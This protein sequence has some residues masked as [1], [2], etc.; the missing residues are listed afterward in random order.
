MMIFLDTGPAQ[1]TLAQRE[2]GDAIGLAQLLTPLTRYSDRGGMY[3]IDNGAFSRFDADGF[4]RLLDRQSSSVDRCKFV[5][6]P[7]VVGSGIRTSEV[8]ERWA[9][10][11]SGWPLAYV[12]QDGCESL[13]IPWDSIAAVFIGGSTAWKT[14]PHAEAVVRAAKALDKWCH[15]GRVNTPERFT[16]FAELGADSCDGS[17][18][19]K[20]T[21]MR[22]ALVR[23][24]TGLFTGESYESLE[25]VSV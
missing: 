24:E 11:L 16:R 15:V 18:I 19:S 6:V 1:W 23:N 25:R 10:R 9:P 4:M 2:I 8:F 17:G 13:P 12:A 22:Q 21:W 7:D 14:G 3:A 20:Y 5:A